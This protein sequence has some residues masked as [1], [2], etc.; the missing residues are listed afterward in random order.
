VKRENVTLMEKVTLNNKEQKRLIVLN[1]VLAGRL[2]GQEA[3]EIL[4]LS[5]RHTR[6]LLAAYRQEG[7]KAL[8][9]GNRGR[10][11]VNKLAVAVE[12]EILHLARGEYVDYNDSHFMEELAERHEI[13]AAMPRR[14]RA[15]PLAHSV[16]H[17]DRLRHNQNRLEQ[18]SCT[19]VASWLPK[20]LNPSP[21]P[22]PDSAAQSSSAGCSVM[23]L[24]SSLVCLLSLSSLS[25]VVPVAWGNSIQLKGC[26]SY[27]KLSAI[28]VTSRCRYI[29][30]SA[31]WAIRSGI[32][33][34]PLPIPNRQ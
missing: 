11:P 10:S 33:A 4:G 25:V 3:A 8:A 28:G 34:L 16:Y 27:C 1:E 20:A 14:S 18:G 31:V 6:R 7:A 19:L 5:L 29:L 17:P 22:M 2:T 24:P 21:W 13:E 30:R 26:R 12:A 15:L 23:I 32:L 9:H